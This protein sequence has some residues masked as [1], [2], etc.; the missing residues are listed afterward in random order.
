MAPRRGQD[1][2]FREAKE[3]APLM[4]AKAGIQF[5]AKALGAFAGTSPQILP[6]RRE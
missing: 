6:H 1:E 3:F 5:F 4:P 2:R